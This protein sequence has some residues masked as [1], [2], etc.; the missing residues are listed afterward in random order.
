VLSRLTAY[1][2]PVLLVLDDFDAVTDT[3][4]IASPGRAGR[5]RA[6]SLKVIA[7][8][9]GHPPIEAPGRLGAPEL[10]FTA[11]ESRELLADDQG[12]ETSVLGRCSAAPPI[13]RAARGCSRAARPR[14]RS[15]GGPGGGA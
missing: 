7:V 3:R 8:T 13:T 2:R 12:S 11:G 14:R 10:A 15:P 4:A 5:D 6:P 9:R 1:G